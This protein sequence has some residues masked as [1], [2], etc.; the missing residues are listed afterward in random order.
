[1]SAAQAQASQ[2][3]A[4]TAPRPACWV[5]TDGKIG[6]E[7][8]CVG[9]AEA[10]GFA[11]EIK[12]LVTRAPWRW[13]TPALWPAG[14][15]AIHPAG[16]QL[17]PPWP[18]LVIA[19]GRQSVVPALAVK[20]ASAGR[21]FLVQIQRPGVAPSRFDVVVTPAHD[22]LAGGNVIET[23]GSMHRISADR[24]AAD[25]ATFA[26]GVAHLPRPLVA[27][28]LGGPNK[29]YRW[30]DQVT[31]R[32]G[33]GLA[34]LCTAQ[35]CGLAVSA[36]RRTGHRAF[37]GLRARLAGLPAVFWRDGD[38]PNPY[39][40]WL[41]LAD[42]IVA[43]GDSVNMVSEACSTG[44]PVFVM[45]LEGGSA[46]FRRFHEALAEAGMTRPFAGRL[47]RWSYTPLDEPA[48]VAAEISARF[49]AHRER[50]SAAVQQRKSPGG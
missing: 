9:L 33:E 3:P 7:S 2:P 29:V 42:A 23:L 6:M 17:S 44:K 43:T 19:T 45:P 22:R 21:T 26:P 4:A 40:G 1:M 48:R 30:T 47:E 12:R 46:K 35:G 18:D 49:A 13:L 16:D 14:L 34:K 5:V 36:S 27:V 50:Q 38:G 41:A 15:G 10:M 8:Q 25:A 39:F 11:P 31:D 32:L 20:R 24:L 37:D 28:L